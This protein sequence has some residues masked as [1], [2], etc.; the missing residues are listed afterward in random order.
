MYTRICTWKG[1]T[2]IEDCYHLSIIKLGRAKQK[3]KKKS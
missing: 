1:K 3:Q 2:K